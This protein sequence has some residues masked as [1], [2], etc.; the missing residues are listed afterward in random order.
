MEEVNTPF[1]LGMNHSEMRIYSSHKLCQACERIFLDADLDDPKKES[2]GKHHPT[3][4]ALQQS[5][6]RG[7]RLCE[8]IRG[9]RA[10]RDCSPTSLG[11]DESLWN[12]GSE[13][14]ISEEP[15][16]PIRFLSFLFGH[17]PRRMII[18]STSRKSDLAMC[19]ICR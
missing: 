14:W 12:V 4:Q 17:E 10:V 6:S 1:L 2:S 16:K 11:E 8:T 18:H 19:L 7:C 9:A 15:A 3:L 5:A 13:G